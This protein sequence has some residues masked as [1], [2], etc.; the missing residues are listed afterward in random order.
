VAVAHRVDGGGGRRD[1]RAAAL[2]CQVRAV[3]VEA[4]AAGTAPEIGEVVVVVVEGIGLVLNPQL[5]PPREAPGGGGGVI[6]MVASSGEAAVHVYVASVVSSSLQA[7][8]EF[9]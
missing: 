5:A 8:F 1:G 9:D 3:I 2:A 4:A 6:D 7:R